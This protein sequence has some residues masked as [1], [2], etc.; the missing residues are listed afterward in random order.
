MGNLVSK[1][2]LYELFRII[3]PGS[4]VVYVSHSVYDSWLLEI[5]EPTNWLVVT[6][7]A[8][9]LSLIIGSIIYSLDLC[10]L[11]KNCIKTLPTNLMTKNYPE[12]YP[13]GKEY[14][15]KNEHV[16][17]EWYEN[18]EINSKVKTELQSGLY[19]MSVN[20]ALVALIGL[21]A[22]L[23]TEEPNIAFLRLNFMLVLLSVI[24][25][26]VVVNFRLKHQWKRNYLEFEKEII[27]PKI[28]KFG[29]GVY[30]MNDTLDGFIDEIL[31]TF[32]RDITDRVFLMIEE[33]K[34]LMQNYLRIVSTSGLDTVNKAIGKRIKSYYDLENLEENNN[35]KSKLIKSYT[36]HSKKF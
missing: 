14:C 27:L 12:L 34:S 17:Y 15:R 9:I 16:Y 30:T 26:I 2:N 35:P 5:S 13:H 7:I 24:S 11:F 28:K 33:D 10:R 31:K 6:L 20:I 21:C 19:H 22:A 1:F 18:S 36:E 25:A 8:L 32:N 23:F 3:L 29:E 4:Y